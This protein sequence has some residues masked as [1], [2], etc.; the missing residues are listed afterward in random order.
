MKRTFTFLINSASNGKTVKSFLQNGIQL[1][2]SEI[3]RLKYSEDG[4]LLNGNR[5]FVTAII[6]DGDTLSINL[7]DNKKAAINP[8]KGDLEILFEDNDLMVVDKPP[9]MPVHPSKGHVDDSLANIVISYLADNNDNPVFRCVTRLD[10]NTSGVVLLA[11]NSFSHDRLRKQLIEHKIIKIYHAIVHGETDREGTVSAP[12]IRPDTATIKREVSPDGIYAVTNYKTIK[13]END[14]SFVEIYPETGRTHQ[15]RV[16]MA[17]IDHPLCGDFL[18]G[19]ENDGYK[20][21]MLHAYEISFTHPVT[22]EE[23][24]VRSKHDIW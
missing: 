17:Y 13:T 23:L 24:T 22:G 6:H 3:K 21:H 18:Y 11:K 16:H 8:V 14:I 5:V 19:D 10:R 12:I 20:R 15:I 7:S 9:F 4:F 2:N 1:S